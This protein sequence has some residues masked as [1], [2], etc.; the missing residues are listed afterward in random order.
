VPE[1]DTVHRWAARLRD[2]LIGHEL[3]RV[4][5]RRAPNGLRPPAPG[6]HVTDVEAHGKHLLVRF[7]DGA[8]LHTHMMVAGAWQIYRPGARWRRPPHTAR[9]VLATD[10]GT[11]AVCFDAPVV[12]I[13]RD[14]GARPTTRAADALARLG[15]DLC[16]DEVDLHEVIARV[17]RLDPATPIGDALLDQRVAAGIGNVYK[18]EICWARRV[19]PSTPIAAVSADLRHALFETARTQLRANLGGGRRV[20]YRGGLAVYG[21]QRRPCPRCRTPIRRTWTGVDKRVTYWCPTCQPE[22]TAP[23]PCGRS[24]APPSASPPQ[25]A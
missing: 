4:E 9:V 15:P 11:T 13:S 8:T 22:A 17:G 24:G 5:I 7:D 14:T 10:D 19:H 21:K 25:G 12:E 23:T 18:S 3:T 20:T 16:A 1:G 2:A 6:V